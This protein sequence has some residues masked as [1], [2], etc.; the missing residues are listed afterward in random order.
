MTREEKM[1]FAWSVLVCYY[2]DTGTCYRKLLSKGRPI[3]LCTKN[4]IR[5]CTREL[6][7]TDFDIFTQ[8][9]NH[10]DSICFYRESK[11]WQ[12]RTD[13]SVRNLEHA[14][15]ETTTLLSKLCFFLI[16]RSQSIAK[17]NE[18][19]KLQDQNLLMHQ[20]TLNQGKCV[21]NTI[22]ETREHISNLNVIELN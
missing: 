5:A 2:D 15:T 4:D 16:N 8:F 3:P 20:E 11:E 14:A 19:L 6:S 9:Y 7:T 21:L 22:T 12:D 13:R 1:Q 18:L 10:G 17:E